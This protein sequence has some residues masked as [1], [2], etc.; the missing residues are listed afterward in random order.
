MDEQVSTTT[1]NKVLG[2][3]HP[4]KGCS[5]KSALCQYHGSIVHSP[6]MPKKYIK[7]STFG[8]TRGMAVT[9]GQKVLLLYLKLMLSL[10]LARCRLSTSTCLGALGTLLIQST[11][12]VQSR[13]PI[14]HR[15]MSLCGRIHLQWMAP[16]VAFLKCKCSVFNTY[17]QDWWHLSFKI[18]LQPL[19]LGI[20]SRTSCSLGKPFTVKLHPSHSQM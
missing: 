1:R 15:T 3:N 12:C 17:S 6:N 16:L 14:E 2:Q 9:L 10:P 13:R 11:I 19:L 18:N 20:S 7:D 8:W 5:R 4:S